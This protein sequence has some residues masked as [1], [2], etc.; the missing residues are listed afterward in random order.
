MDFTCHN[1]EDKTDQM[2]YVL[3]GRKGFQISTLEIDPLLPCWNCTFNTHEGSHTKLNIWTIKCNL[4]QL[5]SMDNLHEIKFRQGSNFNRKGQFSTCRGHYI[6]TP[7]KHV[8]F[9]R[10]RVTPNCWKMTPGYI[11]TIKKWPPVTFQ[12]WKMTGRFILQWGQFS[13]LHRRQFRP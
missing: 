3:T 1:F 13:T 6:M 11:L 2:P 8:T 12:R 9:Q 10:W 5:N 4:V 7:A